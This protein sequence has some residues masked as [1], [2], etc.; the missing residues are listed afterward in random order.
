MQYHHYEQLSK[1]RQHVVGSVGTIDTL[2]RRQR[3]D[4]LLH[5]VR[6]FKNLILS[7][8][9]CPVPMFGVPNWSGSVLLRLLSTSAQICEAIFRPEIALIHSPVSIGQR[10]SSLSSLSVESYLTTPPP[11]GI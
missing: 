8:R 6:Y 3:W 11:C 9:L 2:L 10:E 1:C 5:V 7:K 4:T